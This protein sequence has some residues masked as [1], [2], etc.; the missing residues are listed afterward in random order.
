MSPAYRFWNN[1]AYFG[2][3]MFIAM[4]GYVV[5]TNLWPTPKHIETTSLVADTSAS[6]G[7]QIIAT[8]HIIKRKDCPGE[9][10]WNFEDSTGH[11]FRI[12]GGPL[13]VNPPGEYDFTKVLTIPPS[14]SKGPGILTS[15]LIKTCEEGTTIDRYSV[16][17]EIE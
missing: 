8:S 2:W 16:T 13:G 6:P 4:T 11:N 12:D 14:A 9:F 5:T 10:F 7:T 15:V 1:V 3:L 17:V